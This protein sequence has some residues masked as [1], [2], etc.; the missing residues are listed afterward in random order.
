MSKFT[1][2]FY[3]SRSDHWI[4]S[5][6]LDCDE[7]DARKYGEELCLHL[8]DEGS[9]FQIL[10]GHRSQ[11]QVGVTEPYHWTMDDCTGMWDDPDLDKTK[12]WFL[13]RGLVKAFGTL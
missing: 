13:E 12:E 6:W 9:V 10:P 2:A 5:L 7:G 3:A 8:F 11:I 4:C 1:A